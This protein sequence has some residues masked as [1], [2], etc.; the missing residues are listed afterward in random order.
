MP[1]EALGWTAE[2]QAAFEVCVRELEL[3]EDSIASHK[4]D[5]RVVP[6]RV[7]SE[8]RSHFQVAVD[9]GEVAAEL[10]G[11]M[12]QDV[13]VRSDLPGVGDFV[14][15]HL[16]TSDGPAII[17]ALLPRKTALVRRAAGERR[18]QLIAANVDVVMIVTAL[19]GDYSSERIERYLQ[20][21][22]DGGGLPVILLN[23]ADVGEGLTEAL[24][25]LG[26]MAG[27]VPVHVL[28]A[29][30]AADVAVLEQYFEGGKTIAM[31]GSSGVGKSTLTNQLLGR[32]AQ[33][34]QAVSAH[35]NRGRHTTTHRELFARP[36]GGA[37]MDTPGMGGLVIWE[38]E[39]EAA[40]VE[41]DFE[42]IEALAA[43]C[44]F[45]NCA[46]QTEPACAVRAAIARGEIEAQYLARYREAMR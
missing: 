43:Q 35:D 32:D 15:V 42:D 19:D 18:P 8:H 31:I 13:A 14:A 11:R 41:E 12:W 45:R 7:T 39:E 34:T 5:R 37:V 23:K 24:A 10:P 40:E 28:S 21:V 38:H 36:G 20:V 16:S 17:E 9:G 27:D 3:S 46:H 25:A 2:W 4:A 33:L 26:E 44:K 1:L 29:L 6:G 22:R 30:D